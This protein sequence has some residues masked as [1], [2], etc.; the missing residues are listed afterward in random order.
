MKNLLM[1]SV[2]FFFAK[3]IRNISQHLNQ[4][5]G[6]LLETGRPSDSK[7]FNTELSCLTPLTANNIRQLMKRAP[8]KSCELD[9]LP[10]WLLRHCDDE[11]VETITT[12][13]NN[14]LTSSCVPQEYKL[15]IVKPLLIEAELM[16]VK[17]N[18]RPISNLQYVSK[19]IERAVSAQLVAHMKGND[20]FEPFQSAY[21]EGY[22]TE[23]ALLM[24][25]VRVNDSLSRPF[26]LSCGVPQGSV[27]GPI[28]FNIYTLPLGD[29]VKRQ[30]LRYH[31]YADDS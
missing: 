10:T 27:L 7:M 13:I 2:V 28:S 26:P 24:Q 5:A 22:S 14:S 16:L 4:A 17:E 30:G 3:K 9:P 21:R 1:T 11:V 31:L 20:L 15:A 18:Y 8:N 19:L 23:T 6:S 25:Q 12:I 29:L